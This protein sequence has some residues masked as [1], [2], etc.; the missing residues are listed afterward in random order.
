MGKSALQTFRAIL[1]SLSVILTTLVTL[2]T[3]VGIALF[4][5]IMLLIASSVYVIS[6][7]LLNS[8]QPVEKV[9]NKLNSKERHLV[10]SV[11]RKLIQ[12]VR[13]SSYPLSAMADAINA[14]SS[15][16]PNNS[17]DFVL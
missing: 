4:A 5:C 15:P 10:S 3:P 17:A 11:L 14:A 6:L 13:Q 1:R 7:I 12:A 8:I 9:L 2:S 16:M